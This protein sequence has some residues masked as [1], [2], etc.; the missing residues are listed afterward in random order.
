MCGGQV[1]VSGGQLQRLALVRA[2]L[3]EPEALILDE[4]TSM[5]DVLTQA[6][7]M[8][9]IRCLQADRG[10]ACLFI[11]HDLDLAAAFAHRIAVMDA[12][13]IVETALTS[14]L[15]HAPE[16]DAARALAEAFDAGRANVA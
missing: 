13:R 7:V 3:V 2:L 16:S 12:G 1:T 9:S 15:R 4:P 11:T 6:Q 14:R 8:R 5:L 10:L